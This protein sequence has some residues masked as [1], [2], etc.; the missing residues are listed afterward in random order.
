MVCGNAL[1]NASKSAGFD[2][3]VIRNNLVVFA[4]PLSSHPNV[5]TFLSINNIT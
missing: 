1:K 2:W 5:R 3:G 4:A